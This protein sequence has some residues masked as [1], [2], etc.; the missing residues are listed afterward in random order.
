MNI[1][2]FNNIFKQYNNIYILFKH[3]KPKVK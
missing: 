2:T 1:E 3:S